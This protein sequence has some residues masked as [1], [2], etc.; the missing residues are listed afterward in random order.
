MSRFT[1]DDLLALS[2]PYI[3]FLPIFPRPSFGQTHE[4]AAFGDT[5]TANDII[6]H[7]NSSV[8]TAAA[9]GGWSCFGPVWLIGA[10]KF[11]AILITIGHKLRRL[12]WLLQFN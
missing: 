1:S 9:A 5:A 12:I 8:A 7:P 4:P 2:R 6:I 10:R 11:V 3:I